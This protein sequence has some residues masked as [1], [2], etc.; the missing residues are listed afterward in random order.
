MT[1]A[2]RREQISEI[3]HS[4][5]QAI[6]ASKLASM[7]SVSRQIIVGDIALLRTA[8]LEIDATP[9]GYVLHFEDKGIEKQ[10]VCLHEGEESMAEELNICVDYGCRVINVIVDHPLYG[11]LT[12]EL[13][14]ESRYDVELFIEKAR[15]SEAL[16]LSALTDGVH[17]HT[18]LCD[19]IDGYEMAV[20][21]LKE[22]GYMLSEE[23]GK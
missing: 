10:I 9:R 23:S 1:A 14:I 3:L 21:K 8:G 22:K 16:P 18:L 17:T 11:K 13:H 20:K 6:S 5:H 4:E 7:L 2:E 15:E 12:G 19:S